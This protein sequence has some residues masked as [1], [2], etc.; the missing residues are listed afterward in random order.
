ME[1]E[2]GKEYIKYS[3]KYELIKYNRKAESSFIQWL[4]LLY[5]MDTGLKLRGYGRA[6]SKDAT[7]GIPSKQLVPLLLY[8]GAASCEYTPFPVSPFL[9]YMCK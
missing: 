4:T 8:Q 9:H 7:L 3:G 1:R 2:E 5:F 6:L